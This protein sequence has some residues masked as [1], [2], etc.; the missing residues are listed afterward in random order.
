MKFGERNWE[1][2]DGRRTFPEFPATRFSSDLH[3]DLLDSSSICCSIRGRG[4]FDLEAKRE[5]DWSLIDLVARH[6]ILRRCVRFS[7]RSRIGEGLGEMGNPRI[8]LQ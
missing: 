3:G 4:W 2:T 6:L 7:E 8:S 5:D 1:E